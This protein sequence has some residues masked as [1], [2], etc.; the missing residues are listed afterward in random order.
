MPDSSSYAG[1]NRFKFSG[2]GLAIS[3][4]PATWPGRTPERGGLYRGHKAQF[5]YH[6]ALLKHAIQLLEASGISNK[7]ETR[8]NPM[9]NVASYVN[10]ANLSINVGGTS[11]AYCD[12]GPR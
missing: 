7:H 1:T 12:L 11:F 6:E 8:S 2:L 9:T 4:I 5:Q 10:A 3:A